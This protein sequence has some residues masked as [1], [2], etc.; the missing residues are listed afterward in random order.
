MH[1]YAKPHSL[2]IRD[3]DPYHRYI[4]D[5]RYRYLY[6]QCL[7]E[8]CQSKIFSGRLVLERSPDSGFSIASRT[9]AMLLLWGR[10]REYTQRQILEQINLWRVGDFPFDTFPAQSCL[11]LIYMLLTYITYNAYFFLL[12][13]GYV[14]LPTYNT[15]CRLLTSITCNWLKHDT[16]NWNKLQYNL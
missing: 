11:G 15:L 8:S 3:Q 16:Q 7:I 5:I 2:K 12:T 13:T 9:Q 4:F 6:Y 1:P 14:T 10:R